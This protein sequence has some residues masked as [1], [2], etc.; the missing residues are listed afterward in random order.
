MLKKFVGDFRQVGAW[1]NDSE[2]RRNIRNGSQY[3]GQTANYRKSHR[4][5]KQGHY[6]DE[7]GI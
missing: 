1:T 5:D 3:H 4:R 2:T 6:K 7:G